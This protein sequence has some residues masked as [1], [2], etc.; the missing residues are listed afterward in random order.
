MSI[1]VFSGL[2]ALVMSAVEKVSSG[3]GFETYHTVWFFEVNYF[4]VLVL[5]GAL[6]VVLLIG[7]GFQLYEHFQWRALEKKYGV[8]DDN[9]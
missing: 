5:L 4:S 8:R 7:A 9:V 6:I 3:H 1:A 2:G